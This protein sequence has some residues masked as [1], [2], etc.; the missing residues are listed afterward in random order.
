M[1]D[2]SSNVITLP[3]LCKE[4][5]EVPF[6]KS[7]GTTSEAK[8]SSCGNRKSQA[9]ERCLRW[10]AFQRAQQDKPGFRSA[11]PYFQ[12][13]GL[14]AGRFREYILKRVAVLAP[15][16]RQGAGLFWDFPTVYGIFS[17]GFTMGTKL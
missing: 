4:P 13:T 8:R 10:P 15:G 5:E 9:L 16:F 11:L 7:S 2:S 6:L 14:G 1:S 3:R 12:K 17:V